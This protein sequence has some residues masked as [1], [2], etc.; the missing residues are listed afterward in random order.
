[1]SKYLCGFFLYFFNY[2]VSKLSFIDNKSTIHKKA[3][4]YRG[5]QV[6]NSTI[7]AHTYIAP[8]SCIIHSHIGK[9]CSISKNVYI[10]LPKHSF[11]TLSTSPLFLS[12]NN[13]LKTSW[14]KGNSFEE[15]ETVEIGNDVWIG[16]NVMIK[17]GVKISDG[18]VIGAGS[19]VTK[20]VPPFAIVVGSPAKVIKYRFS[21]DII[22]MI[23][24]LK[25]WN[26]SDK[27]LLK[28]IDLFRNE[29]FYKSKGFENLLR[30]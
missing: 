14:V 29:D 20:D 7:D 24:S 26:M 9:F 4:V 30:K 16:M 22:G 18:A 2:R 27:S 13:A 5:C 23:L 28:N 6:F 1:M 19:I 3:K 15:F 11:N 25:W 17:G 8:N 10:G 12:E 21:E